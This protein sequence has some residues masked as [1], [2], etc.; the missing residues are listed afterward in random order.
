[1]LRRV[2]WYKF[3]GVSHVLAASIIRMMSKPHAKNWFLKHLWNVGKLLPDY[4]AQHPR[5]QPSSYSPPWKP[6]ISHFSDAFSIWNGPNSR[7][8]YTPPHLYKLYT[9][10]HPIQPTNNQH[11]YRLSSRLVN[12]KDLSTLFYPWDSKHQKELKIHKKGILYNYIN[13]TNGPVWQ[14]PHSTFIHIL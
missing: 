12:F 7:P 5:R 9:P 2:D 13:V 11:N 4:T 1:M 10:V 3:T 14:Q 6:Q 8:D